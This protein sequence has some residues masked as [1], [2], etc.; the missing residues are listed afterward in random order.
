LNY[1]TILYLYR[2]F[3]QSIGYQYK[4]IHIAT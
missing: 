3:N 4:Q 1:I 2:F